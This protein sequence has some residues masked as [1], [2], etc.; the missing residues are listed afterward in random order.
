MRNYKRNFLLVQQSDMTVW[1]TTP[2]TNGHMTVRGSPPP[3]FL[4]VCARPRGAQESTHHQNGHM[5]IGGLTAKALTPHPFFLKKKHIYIYIFSLNSF[6]SQKYPSS[7]SKFSHFP[8]NLLLFFFPKFLILSLSLYFS[9][10]LQL[11]WEKKKNKA[12]PNI[13]N[14]SHT[15]LNL[16]SPTNSS[17]FFPNPNSRTLQG[18]GSRYNHKSIHNLV[19][20]FFFFFCFC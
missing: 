12:L 15:I 5:T 18:Q 8:F 13:S 19:F 17:I 10:F 1:S 7:H 11:S 16:Y 4:C 14:F 9:L 6:P 3:L 2:R 20:F